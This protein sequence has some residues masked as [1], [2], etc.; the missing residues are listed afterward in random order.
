MEYVLF[1]GQPASASTSILPTV[2]TAG[3]T[4]IFTF[5]RRNASTSD[6]TQSFQYG[7]DLSGWTPVAIP[8]GAGVLVTPNNPTSGIE[9]VDV[10][11]SKGSNTKLF[12]RLKVTTP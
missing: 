3:N 9:K 11:V 2:N 7:S 4:F 6:T 1:N 10:T 5:Y 8:G 12:G